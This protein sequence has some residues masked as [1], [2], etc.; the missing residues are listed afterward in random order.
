MTKNDLSIHNVLCILTIKLLL[1]LSLSCQ[2]VFFQRFIIFFP[3]KQENKK[4][5]KFL[6]V[7]QCL[8][9]NQ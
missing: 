6:G 5:K 3:H 1:H 9:I 8:D 2:N 7:D 4:E